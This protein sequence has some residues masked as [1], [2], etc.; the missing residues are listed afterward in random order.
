M[1]P[2]TTLII[3]IVPIK[4]KYVTCICFETA[5]LSFSNWVLI[6]FPAHSKQFLW[7]LF[8]WSNPRR[9]LLLFELPVIQILFIWSDFLLPR[10]GDPL[11][12]L[13][14]FRSRYIFNC[15]NVYIQ[16]SYFLH[17]NILQIMFFSISIMLG[18]QIFRQIWKTFHCLQSLTNSWHTVKLFTSKYFDLL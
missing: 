12:Y 7:P 15:Y 18:Y 4:I 9:L 14:L 6:N 16:Q 3:L 10:T 8:F 13:K 5:V 11:S 2:T 1:F 17:N